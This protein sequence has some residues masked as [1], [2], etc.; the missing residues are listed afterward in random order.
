MFVT[1]FSDLVVVRFRPFAFCCLQIIFSFSAFD[2][3]ME[4]GLLIISNQILLSCF[5]KGFFF[6]SV[7][8]HFKFE[9]TCLYGMCILC[10][11][12]SH[13]SYAVDSKQDKTLLMNGFTVSLWTLLVLHPRKT[14]F[15]YTSYTVR[16]W[17]ESQAGELKLVWS[18]RCIDWKP[19][20]GT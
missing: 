13:I 11:S 8:T 17:P 7:F 2:L 4:C 12:S 1:E 20:R 18:Q 19:H 9:P 5:V 16:K 15:S 10:V 3:L 6:V 14:C